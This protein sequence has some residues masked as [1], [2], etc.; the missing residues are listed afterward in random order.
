MLA[1]ALIIIVA[2][3]IFGSL[4][5]ALASL[6]VKAWAACRFGRERIDRYYR[7]FFAFSGLT[8]LA[9]VGLSS[10]LPDRHLYT[11][12]SPWLILTT[13]VQV[14][15][16]I[17][18]LIAL[19]QTDVMAFVG[20]RQM[21]WGGEPIPADR[22][23]KLIVSGPYR[24]VRHPLYTTAIVT[25]WLFPTMTINRAALCAVTAA[26]FYLGSYPEERKL[27]LEFGQAYREYQRRTP[28]LIPFFKPSL[29]IIGSI[30]LTLPRQ[31]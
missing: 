20:L 13:L 26:Y 29:L 3:A 15:A 23:E 27:I 1:S 14:A 9:V 10:W 21:I 31:C 24:W 19:L 30:L 18:F 25:S 11:I 2:G 5:T 4:H 22:H 7:L 28:R 16:G 17:V 8:Y 6:R 12:P